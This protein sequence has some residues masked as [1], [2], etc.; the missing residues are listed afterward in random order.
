MAKSFFVINISR[1]NAEGRSPINLRICDRTTVKTYATGFYADPGTQKTVK[2]ENGKEKKIWNSDKDW[3]HDN[4]CFR[5]GKGVKKF[6]VLR[7]EE[8]GVK[9]YSNTDANAELS[10]FKKKADKILKKY[11]EDQV[12]WSMAMFDSEFRVKRTDGLFFEYA[13]KEVIERRYLALGK[14]K[15][16]KVTED[17]LHDLERFYTLELGKKKDGLAIKDIDKDFI[18]SYIANCYS[19]GVAENPDEK[20][21]KG[22][23]LD[24][25]PRK[26]S[27]PNTVGIRL[28]EIRRILNLAMEDGVGSAQTY[29]FGGRNGVEIPKNKTAKRFLSM[30]SLRKIA[31]ARM[32]DK[33]KET[34]R[35]LFLLSFHLR[36]MNYKDMAE[37]RKKNIKMEQVEDGELKKVLRYRRSKTKEDFVIVITP[38]IQAELDWFNE[39]TE[40]IGDYLLPIFRLEPSPEGREEY[41][42][43]RRKRWNRQLKAIA[44]DLELPEEM[45]GK[46]VSAYW[47]RHSFAM[48]MRHKGESI[49]KISQALGHAD[50]ETT[51]TYL[52]SFGKMEMA[53]ATDIDLG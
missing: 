47:S 23:T 51:K 7:R 46:G 9:E 53:K 2:D 14:Y 18:D 1:T 26:A 45:Q 13:Q 24:G 36:G 29:P 3:D 35:H 50:V 41:L 44:K 42:Q 8:G 31:S 34:A 30:D 37:L 19:N 28:R 5:H 17:A 40:T 12:D 6:S 48:A 16:A 33:A 11:D 22:T 15:R 43:Q 49:E 4:H 27:T 52:A 10:A 21:R 25:K 38:R 39:N 20:P 32:E